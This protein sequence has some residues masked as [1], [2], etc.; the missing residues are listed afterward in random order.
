MV[1]GHF[2][3]L[4]LGIAILNILFPT[5]AA[6]RG[7]LN[8][9]KLIFPLISSVLLAYTIVRAT[10]ENYQELAALTIVAVFV[11]IIAFTTPVI[12][13][14]LRLRNPAYRARMERIIQRHRQQ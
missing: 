3:A 6:C 5:F 8:A 2:A 12:R 9:W 4:A 14:R 7:K 13:A 10:R 11:Q 1:T